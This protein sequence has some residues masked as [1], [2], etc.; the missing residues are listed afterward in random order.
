LSPR[1]GLNRG[2]AIFTALSPISANGGRRFYLRSGVRRLLS[3]V[4]TTSDF[5]AV[6]RR[7]R[8][9]NADTFRILDRDVARMRSF[10][11]FVNYMDS[12]WPYQAPANFLDEFSATRSLQDPYQQTVARANAMKSRGRKTSELRQLISQYDA[13]IACEDA[14]FGELMQ[15]LKSEGIYDRA[16]IVVT[17]DH[18]EAFGDRGLVDHG[19]SVYADQT[20]VPLLIK[21]PHQTVASVVTAPVSHVDILP[22]VMDVAGYPAPPYV[23][24]RSLR[25]LD[26][27]GD[28]QVISESFPSMFISGSDRVE[29]ALRHGDMKLVISTAGKRE[30]Y[31]ESTDPNE[32]HNMASSGG[33]PTASLETS[34]REWIAHVPHPGPPR[35]ISRDPAEMR[36]LKSLGYVQ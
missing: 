6:F 7:A 29:R 22:T 12:H 33:A 15:R 26:E 11:L 14:A 23:Q 35:P 31:N 32:L 21:Y 36:R 18:G 28:R 10:F 20:H 13:G 30:L 4:R 24:G 2:F 27:L 5:D 19:S 17:G 9:V 34:L 8:D 3:L 1:W 16:L 25:K